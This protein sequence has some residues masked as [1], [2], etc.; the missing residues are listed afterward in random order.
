MELFASKQD[1][2]DMKSLCLCCKGCGMVMEN[3]L[4]SSGGPYIQHQN[5]FKKGGLALE[6]VINV[7]IKL[8]MML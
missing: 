2:C 6:C 1:D 7:C 8:G 5:T 4:F 3:S